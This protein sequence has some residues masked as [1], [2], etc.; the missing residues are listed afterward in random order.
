MKW[1][2]PTGSPQFPVLAEVEPLGSTNT[3]TAV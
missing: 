3:G 2:H 1:P